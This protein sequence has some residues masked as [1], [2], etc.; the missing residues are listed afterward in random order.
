MTKTASFLT[1]GSDGMLTYFTSGSDLDVAGTYSVQ[2]YIAMPDF[3]GYSTP[4]EFA[5]DANL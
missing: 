5:V 2:A 1:D 3:T 4:T